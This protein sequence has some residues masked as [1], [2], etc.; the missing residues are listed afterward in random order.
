MW[1]ALSAVDQG[2]LIYK[3][4]KNIRAIQQLLGNTK[5]KNAV[6]YLGVD[7]ALELRTD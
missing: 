3:R 2:N 4:T 5:L 7:D 6:R 1:H